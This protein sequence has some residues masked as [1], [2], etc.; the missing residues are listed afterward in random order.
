MA[1]QYFEE[2]EPGR[3]FEHAWSR[4]VTEMDN[5]LFS[6]L[7]LNVQP[8]HLDEHF[9]AGTEWGTVV[10][11]TGA[12]GRSTKEQPPCSAPLSTMPTTVA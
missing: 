7:T 12:A 1:G 8:L 9:A 5:V 4:T 2:L 11:V 6:T 3:S 10:V